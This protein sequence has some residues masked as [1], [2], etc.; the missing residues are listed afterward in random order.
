[1]NFMKRAFLYVS[2]KRGKSI[3]L[4]F[5]LLILSTFVLTGLS[6]GSA[7]KQAQ[8]NLRQNIGGS[9]NIDV[10]YSDS[11]PYYHEEESEN[12][13]GS[14]DLLMYSTEQVTSKMVE[15]IRNISGV[16]FCDA[17]TESLINFDKLLP[18]AGTVPLDESLSHCVKSIGV[19]RS[20]EQNFFTSG[21]VQLIEGRHI[22][23]NDIHKVIVCKD[24]KS[25]WKMNAKT[26][27]KRCP[28]S[29]NGKPC[30]VIWTITASTCFLPK[31]PIHPTSI[32]L[33][34][35]DLLSVLK[36]AC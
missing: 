11:N 33:K 7:S 27:S 14:S 9:F 32:L 23:D 22:L 19:W 1:M 8:K 15:N 26:I 29:T 12:E 36:T 16:K 35:M 31:T 5:I 18:F 24:L 6:I 28:D 21:K 13:D 4:F 2:R 3:L 30:S 10:N 20:E 25:L 17:T 34:W